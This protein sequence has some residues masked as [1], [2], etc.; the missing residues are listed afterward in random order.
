[1]QVRSTRLATS[2]LL[3]TI[4]DQSV[5]IEMTIKARMRKGKDMAQANWSFYGNQTEAIFQDHHI[6]KC[7]PTPKAL[8]KERAVALAMVK[9]LI[10]ARDYMPVPSMG[11]E[12]GFVG[13]PKSFTSPEP[14]SPY[15]FQG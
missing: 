11:M 13:E 12:K 15:Q 9:S 1:M 3:R 10:V 14:S 7:S 2:H 5:S 6:W 8:Y 4:R